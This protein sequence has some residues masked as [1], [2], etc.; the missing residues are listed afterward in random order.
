MLVVRGIIF[1]YVNLFRE[2]EEKSDERNM[3]EN[4]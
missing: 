4:L 2:R 3:G 1:Y